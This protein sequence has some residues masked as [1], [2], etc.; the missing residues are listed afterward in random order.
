MS[1]KAGVDTPGNS[2]GA[3]VSVAP[4]KTE[5][6]IRSKKK[7]T[8][9]PCRR[10]FGLCGFEHLQPRWRPLEH[11]LEPHQVHRAQRRLVCLLPRPSLDLRESNAT[12]LCVQCLPPLLF[13][14]HGGNSTQ[15]YVRCIFPPFA[16]EGNSTK[17]VCSFPLSPTPH[18]GPPTKK[19]VQ[20]IFLLV[21]L[22]MKG[23]RQNRAF[24]AFSP[25]PALCMGRNRQICCAFKVFRAA[26]MTTRVCCLHTKSFFLPSCIST[27]GVRPDS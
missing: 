23:S 2:K 18:E 21:F 25:S 26:A 20:R 9:L 8:N 27:P 6:R 14:L 5:N 3:S 12:K 15:L 11:P 10:F 17:P 4:S 16:H 24:N 7:A 22:C 19:Y 1:V 13:A